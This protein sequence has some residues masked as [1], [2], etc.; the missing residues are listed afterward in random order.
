MP[1]TRSALCFTLLC[2]QTPVGR[3]THSVHRPELILAELVVLCSAKQL[4]GDV[5]RTVSA[6]A[7][8][9]A[10]EFLAYVFYFYQ[11]FVVHWLVF[12][13]SLLFYLPD[14]A[15][16]YATSQSDGIVELVRC[17]RLFKYSRW[18]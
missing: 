10:A 1:T 16:G 3:S 4:G 11:Y 9:I 13:R 12:I 5:L 14:S 18:F 17:T 7:F 2:G 15:S 8:E 6:C